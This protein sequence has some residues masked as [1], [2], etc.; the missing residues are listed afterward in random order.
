MRMK[1]IELTTRMKQRRYSTAAN[2]SEW[3]AVDVASVG[4]IESRTQKR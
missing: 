4:G 3:L 1:Y 2:P